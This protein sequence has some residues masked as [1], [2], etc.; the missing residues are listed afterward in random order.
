MF[1]QHLTLA[2]P[3]RNKARSRTN[4]EIEG[5]EAMEK[6]VAD[7]QIDEIIL[8]DTTISHKRLTEILFHCERNLI[9]FRMVPDLYG[10]LTSRVRVNHISDIP[11]LGNWGKPL[12]F[13]PG[14]I[15]VAHTTEEF[16]DE[17]ELRA[18]VEAYMKLVRTLLD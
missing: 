7:E 4:S 9:P 3:A 8:A 1:P 16:V 14:S 11:L 17:A 10:V 13:G 18:S 2:V 12:L 6:V 15:H 5:E